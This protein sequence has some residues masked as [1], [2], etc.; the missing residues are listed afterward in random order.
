[1]KGNQLIAAYEGEIR[2]LNKKILELEDTNKD[3]HFMEELICFA[4]QAAI[5]NPDVVLSKLTEED[6]MALHLPIPI[7]RMFARFSIHQAE[8]VMIE[9]GQ[10][11]MKRSAEAEAEKAETPEPETE[12]SSLIVPP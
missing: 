12:K 10:I 3:G 7:A 9:L 5:A 8:A 11:M 2:R 1:M 4:M 6:K